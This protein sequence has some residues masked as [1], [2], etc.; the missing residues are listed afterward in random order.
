[1]QPEPTTVA[2]TTSAAKVHRQYSLGE[3]FQAIHGDC[4]SLIEVNL[5]KRTAEDRYASVGQHFV[6][7]EQLLV[8]Y[9]KIRK[10]SEEKI[11]QWG[12]EYGLTVFF[13]ACPR[14]KKSGAKDAIR[15]VPCLWADIDFPDIETNQVMPK[16]R[17]YSPQPNVMVFTGHGVHLYWRLD[18]PSTDIEKCEKTMIEIRNE[19]GGDNT[20]NINRMMRL[21]KTWNWKVPDE[22]QWCDIVE[23]V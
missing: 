4:T 3:F 7:R 10:R 18:T 17:A 6:S 8:G 21:P 2:P 23:I 9:P 15:I 22:K 5:M 16:I 14:W 19:L 12:G 13:E 11:A 20:Q 1:M